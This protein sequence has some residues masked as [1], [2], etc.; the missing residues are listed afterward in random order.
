MVMYK[1]FSFL[2]VNI[3][4]KHMNYK[5]LLHLPNKRVE[6]DSLRRRFTPPSLAAHEGRY[7]P[8]KAYASV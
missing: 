6:S 8:I 1:I 2:G 4:H 7:V 5:L 3:F